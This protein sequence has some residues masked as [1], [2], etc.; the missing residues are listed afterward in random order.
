MRTLEFSHELINLSV[1]LT[2]EIGKEF[3]T[4]SERREI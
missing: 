3:T 4:T 2:L 1:G